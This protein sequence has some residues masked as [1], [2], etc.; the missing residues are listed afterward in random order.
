VKPN[1]NVP[2]LLLIIAMVF[3]DEALSAKLNI[4]TEHFPPFQ[5]VESNTITGLSSEI[6][7]ATL[8]TAQF[9]YNLSAYPWSAS[10]QQALKQAN[11]CIYTRSTSRCVIQW[12][13]KR[14]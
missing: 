2:Y 1:N 11:T 4:V 3:S 7:K 6:I 10:Y 9:S 5:I 13:F 14:L 8:K 12:E